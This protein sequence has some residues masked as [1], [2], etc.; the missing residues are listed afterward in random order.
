M[1][2]SEIAKILYEIAEYLEMQD[3]PFKPRA[4]EK[5][6]GNIESLEESV[7]QIYKKGGLKAVEDI[8]GV[9]ASIGEK[10]EEAL[11]TGHVKFYEQLKKKTPVD[12]G[13]LSGVE[14][15]GP[16]K[17]KVLYKKLGV[18]NLKDL[19]KAAKGEKIRNLAGF[20]EKSEKNILEGI[21]F[22]KKGTG[23]FLLGHIEPQVEHIRRELK[24]LKEVE[25]VEVVG[26][27]RRKKE[28]VGD[29]DILVISEKPRPVMEAFILMPDVIK[30][31]GHGA[32]KSSVKLKNGIDVDL[33]VI[34]KHSFGAA[35]Q[36]F[37]GNKDHNVITRQI[38][39]KKGLKLNEYGLFRGNKLIAA[40]TEE[41]IYK[42]LGLRYMDPEIRENGGEVEAAKN[43]KLPKLIPYGSI[44]GD[45]QI[46]TN[47]TDGSNSIEEMARYAMKLGLEYILITDHT[48]SLAMTGGSD[49]KKLE[50]QGKEID[51][52]NS[53]LKSQGSKFKILKG[54]EVNIMKD[55]SLDIKD[56]AL[57]KLDV[58]GAAVHSNFNMPRAEMT[59]RIIKAME[60]PNVDII[61]HPTGR[62]IQKREAYELDMDEI[63]K[64]AKR[65]G[66]VLEIDAFPDRLDLK[67]EYIRKAVA[68]GVKLSIDSDAHT[69]SHMH[70][71]DLGVS[72]ARR[73]WATK[74]DIINA[75][76]LQKMLSRLKNKK[77]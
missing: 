45:L 12:L 16:K 44:R 34:P 19:E 15:L 48:K 1:D 67:D 14:G 36:Y 2:N 11:R 52:I 74:N 63:I 42:A 37:T 22:L 13:S 64:A 57:K 49:E 24:K 55:G 71:L 47:W 29:I 51:K 31:H 61:F 53:K 76:P 5:A 23:R 3:I 18:K 30:V 6:A 21:E 69:T 7:E 38:A 58:V 72:Q 56:E 26:S 65:T 70:F 10:I 4:Y 62:I 40:R 20:G 46:Q 27:Y 43:N 39:I 73:G 77:K 8:P 9:G 54:A 35:M 28:T 25:R 41:E 32:T 50:R 75:W 66:T 33:L 17:I 68:A 60:N 59:R